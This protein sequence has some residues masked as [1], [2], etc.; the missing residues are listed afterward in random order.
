ML[1]AVVVVAVVAFR[2]PG[3]GG[4][5]L[6]RHAAPAVA[7][8]ARAIRVLVA[9]ARTAP[10]ADRLGVGDVVVH[11]RRVLAVPGAGVVLHGPVG[12]AP[13]HGAQVEVEAVFGGRVVVA[14]VVD[15]GVQL[16]GQPAVLSFRARWQGSLQQQEKSG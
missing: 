9:S 6:G 10:P 7:E 16:P 2:L 15:V 3:R 5:V 12:G 8:V 13:V 1:P 14:R 11:V 4:V